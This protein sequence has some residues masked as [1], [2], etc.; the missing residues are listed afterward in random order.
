MGTASSMHGSIDESYKYYLSSDL[1]NSLISDIV[2]TTSL[3][4]SENIKIIEFFS[5]NHYDGHGS[6]TFK[7]QDENIY[8][9]HLKGT[10]GNLV[11]E[12]KKVE[13]VTNGCL[14]NNSF[15][16]TKDLKE[17]FNDQIATFGPYDSSNNNCYTFASNLQNFLL[18][19]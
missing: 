18:S 14:I 15:K 8:C 10:P 6:V 19:E 1:N 7:T 3:Y 12:T 17:F 2:T 11:I 4:H 13:W 16:S 5:A 9:C